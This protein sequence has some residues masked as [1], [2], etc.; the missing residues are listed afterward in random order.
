MKDKSLEKYINETWSTLH[1]EGWGAY[2]LK[3]NSKV[4]VLMS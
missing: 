2:V 1:V 3:R 4:G